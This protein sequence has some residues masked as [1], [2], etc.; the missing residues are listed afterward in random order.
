MSYDVIYVSPVGNY[1]PRCTAFSIVC[2]NFAQLLYLCALIAELGQSP[3][4]SQI[5]LKFEGAV[6][7]VPGPV[8]Q[9]Q[10]KRCK[11][12]NASKSGLKCIYD[13]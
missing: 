5:R 3:I 1:V 9:K 6:N 7:K 10:S 4:G 11:G 2:T 13:E 8:I 12:D